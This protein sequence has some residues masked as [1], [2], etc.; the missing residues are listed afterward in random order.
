MIDWIKQDNPLNQA[1]TQ[2]AHDNL[3]K[4]TSLANASIFWTHDG[5]SPFMAFEKGF[6]LAEQAAGKPVTGWRSPSSH[7]HFFLATKEEVA[8]LIG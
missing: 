7:A 5:D 3:A 1:L 8:R 6:R 2:L 4:L